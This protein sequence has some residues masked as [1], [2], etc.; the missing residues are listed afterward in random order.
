M[1]KKEHLHNVMTEEQLEPLKDDVEGKKP[2]KKRQGW[3]SKWQYI[4]MVISYA[5]GLGN[6]WRFPYLVQQHG[7]GK[8]VYI[9][10]FCFLSTVYLTLSLLTT[11]LL[12]TNLVTKKEINKCMAEI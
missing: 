11:T 7:G 12:R 3:D 4:F 1:V 2:L 5:V 10:C 9:V 6:V 8:W